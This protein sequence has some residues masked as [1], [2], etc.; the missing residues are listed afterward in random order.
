MKLLDED[1]SDLVV[2][3]FMLMAWY[4]FLNTAV[5]LLTRKNR[6]LGSHK[7]HLVQFM[8]LTGLNF[9]IGSPRSQSWPGQ[10]LLMV[11]LG[12]V[13]YSEFSIFSVVLGLVI[14]IHDYQKYPKSV[15]W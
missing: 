8:A 2:P 1:I 10:L 14:H 5:V 7:K 13:L 4:I 15:L 9:L 12:L 11:I 3:I 6:N